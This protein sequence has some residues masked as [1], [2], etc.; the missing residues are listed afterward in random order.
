[1]SRGGG[2]AGGSRGRGSAGSSWGRSRGGGGSRCAGASAGRCNSA[3][4]N[5]NSFTSAGAAAI[6][7]EDNDSGLG[8]VGG[9]DNTTSGATSTS[10]DIRSAHLIHTHGGGVDT[11]GKTI[12]IIAITLNL[13][14]KLG[15]DVAKWGGGLQVDRVPADLHISIAVSIGVGTSSVRRPVTNGV[16]VGTPD[17]SLLN[18]NTRS[19]DVVLGSSG[20]PVGH[21]GHSKGSELLDQGGNKHGFISRQHSL[22]EGNR[23]ASLVN[24]RHGS[25]AILTV[26]LVGERL[27]DF[28]ILITVKSTVL[29]HHLSVPI[30]L[31]Y[32]I[33]SLHDTYTSA[34]LTMDM[35]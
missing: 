32:V 22:A 18:T 35:G 8:A 25:R 19:V 5:G 28:T 2:D 3:S 11:A 6:K 24:G 33:V 16:G 20:A 34:K 27:L 1:M 31:A 17:T 30:S 4:R 21:G 7:L 13:D 14:T 15:L 12:A 23:L 26:R 29:D 10:E 9:S